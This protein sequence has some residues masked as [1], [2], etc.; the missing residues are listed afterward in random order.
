MDSG[1]DS[2]EFDAMMARH[3]DGDLS[4]DEGRRF[5]EVLK[6]E[7][8]RAKQFARAA[9]MHH[10]VR[11]VF[12][13]DRAVTLHSVP[14]RGH[15]S[16]W[17][18]FLAGAVAASV[19]GVTAYL[20]QSERSQ[21][22]VVQS[23]IR[24]E[25]VASPVAYLASSNGCDWGGPS[26]SK[27]WAVGRSVPFGDEIALHEGIAEFRLAN[28][29]ISLS[30]EGPAAIILTSPN[31]LVLRQGKLTTHIPWAVKDFSLMAGTCRLSA[32]DAEIGV[33][34]VGNDVH[35][36]V[37]SGN[38]TATRSPFFN[39]DGAEQTDQEMEATEE[40][41]EQLSPVE[42]GPGEAA[43]F[44][45]NAGGTSEVRLQAADQARF[46][47]K[48][49]M[50]GL[51]PVSQGY[52]DAVMKSK[53]VG[54]W[55]F[56]SIEDGS[57][58][59]EVEAAQPLRAIGEVSLS[60]DK[61]NSV[62]EL[63][64]PQSDGYFVTDASVPLSGANYSVELWAKPSHFHRGV[65]AGMT[66]PNDDPNIPQPEKHG[67]MLETLR[68]YERHLSHPGSIRFLHRNPPG[69]R[70]GTS[71]FSSQLYG[72]RQWQHIVAAKRKATMR[73]YIDGKLVATENDPKPLSAGMRL[74]VGRNFV[75]ETSFNMFS[76]VGQ[77]DELAIY[78][79]ALPESEIADH[80]KAVE[81]KRPPSPSRQDI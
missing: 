16:R 59:N 55:R 29:D 32:R 8:A 77:L 3:L 56:E 26:A 51:L 73:L 46:A 68:G 20:S 70:L 25:A 28:G 42:I 35:V 71:C 10:Q 30:L 48:L 66:I 21:P 75:A 44:S 67:F 18:Y 57:V 13:Y 2:L 43:V 63:G 65:L 81:F 15:V 41:P 80:T 9:A 50:G 19:V 49:S 76:F 53:P 33:D 1:M 62:A 7:P 39:A 5:A 79:R 6:A 38:V 54:Y 14:S 37:F 4:L 74:V 58:R 27:V 72:L 61:Q 17:A 69:I 78:G 24:P 12:K 64:R 31:S 34:V 36:H 52:V 60:G 23:N 11:S 40:N 47:A 22:E 45:T